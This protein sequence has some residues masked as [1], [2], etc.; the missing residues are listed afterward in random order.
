MRI[1]FLENVEVDLTDI[2]PEAWGAIQQRAESNVP[3][4]N[5]VTQQFELPPGQIKHVFPAGA[6]VE[7]PDDIAATYIA[8]GFAEFNA[9]LNGPILWVD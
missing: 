4:V 3:H 8:A 1:R 2:P 6:I 7:L 9:H 5:P